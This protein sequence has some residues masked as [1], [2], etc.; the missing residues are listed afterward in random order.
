MRADYKSPILNIKFANSRVFVVFATCILTLA[1]CTD[2]LEEV[3]SVDIE[4]PYGALAVASGPDVLAVFPSRIT[5][6]VKIQLEHRSIP[7]TF[8]VTGPFRVHESSIAHLAISQDGRIA[9]S[10]SGKGTLLRIF[11]TANG[12]LI[13]EVRRG[14]T[15]AHIHSI[16]VSS[17]NEMIAATSN[18]GTCHIF[19]TKRDNVHS[20]LPDFVPNFMGDA[21][22][23]YFGSEWSS[24]Q[25]PVSA[26][27]SVTYFCEDD[28]LLVV[29][30]AD[31]TFTRIRV[32]THE[33]N[34]VSLTLKESI[35]F[36]P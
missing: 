20:K 6:A 3:S 15:Q 31:G 18:R 13:K 28:T 33:G 9:V 8:R 23:E 16:C 30:S 24:S 36:F 4:N 21:L 1:I 5:G 29:I 11:E 2:S 17:N 32:A 22:P 34:H 10:A 14:S 19:W 27:K 25:L 26:E 12:T 7:K 35:K